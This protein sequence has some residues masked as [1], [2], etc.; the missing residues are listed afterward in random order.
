MQK[1]HTQF[2]HQNLYFSQDTWQRRKFMVKGNSINSNA[3]CHH[4]TCDIAD[5]LLILYFLFYY[6]EIQPFSQN[7]KYTI[8]KI[9]RNNQK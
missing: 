6:K 7:Y 9:R 1:E 4:T 2:P 8:Y 5:T 3:I